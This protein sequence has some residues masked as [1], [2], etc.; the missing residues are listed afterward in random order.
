M[1]SVCL[2][3]FKLLR[4]RHL[5]KMAS[6][7]LEIGSRSPILKINLALHVVHLCCKDGDCLSFFSQVIVQTPSRLTGCTDWTKMATMTLEIGLR[8][9]IFEL[10]LALHVVHLCCKDGDCISFLFP[11]YCANTIGHTDRRTDGCLAS[12]PPTAPSATAGDKK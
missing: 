5:R 6:I 7:T 12:R 3:L 4:K 9:P 11:S 2:F 10:N 1:V 8:S